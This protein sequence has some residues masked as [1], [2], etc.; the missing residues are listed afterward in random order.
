MLF[1]IYSRLAKKL[2]ESHAHL[3]GNRIGPDGRIWLS[4]SE[5]AFP[6]LL[7]PSHASEHR[8]DIALRFI[9]V[10]FS[11]DC[12]IA[13]DEKNVV[14]G[15]YTIVRLN[16]NDPDIVRLFLRL[17]EEAFCR[18]NNGFSN[19]QIGD[20][21]LELSDL[22]SRLHE[23]ASD[24]LGLWGELSI[25]KDA[26]HTL[27]AVRCRC[28]NKNAKYDFV[29]SNFAFEVKTTLRSQRQHTFSIEQLRPINPFEVY[30]AS[31]QLVETSSGMTVADLLEDILSEIHDNNLRGMFLSRCLMKGGADLYRSTLRLQPYPDRTS[32]AI[33]NARNI[34]VPYIEPGCPISNVRFDVDLSGLPSVD[35]NCRTR[36]LAFSDCPDA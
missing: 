3:F 11:R 31:L 5:E 32:L 35:A 16:E 19:R 12:K 28:S 2:P 24:M 21:I 26:A 14:A 34:P 30:V 27:C 36:L 1:E 18:G 20:K 10:E 23:A 9:D 7:F 25:M 22:F 33:F 6:C 4:I 15:T 8:T 17:L 29:A 13:T